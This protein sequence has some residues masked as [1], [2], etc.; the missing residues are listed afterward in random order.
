MAGISGIWHSEAGVGTGD[1]SGIIDGNID[2]TP[3]LEPDEVVQLVDIVD[4][5]HNDEEEEEFRDDSALE[6]IKE[7]LNKEGNYTQGSKDADR[8]THK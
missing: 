8:Q 3:P 4:L 2:P 5:A 7:I 6:L 1:L